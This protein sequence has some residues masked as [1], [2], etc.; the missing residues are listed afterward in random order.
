MSFSFIISL[1]LLYCVTEAKHLLAKTREAKEILHLSYEHSQRSS[2]E[3]TAREKWQLVKPPR[4]QLRG[5]TKRFPIKS[6]QSVHFLHSGRASFFGQI[7]QNGYQR[8]DSE[9]T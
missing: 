9:E 8:D 6:K 3:F 4:S 5:I 2:G 1:G 7:W